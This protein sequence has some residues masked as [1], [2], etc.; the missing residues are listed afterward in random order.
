MRR[1]FLLTY[2]KFY[3]ETV[4]RK[5]EL[6]MKEEFKNK[7]TYYLF[8]GFLGATINGALS[9][10]AITESGNL[11]PAI[12]ISV[13]LALLESYLIIMM[14]DE[15]DTDKMVRLLGDEEKQIRYDELERID[16]GFKTGILAS[17]IA[18]GGIQ[19]YDTQNSMEPAENSPTTI[20]TQNSKNTAFV[21]EVPLGNIVLELPR[22]MAIDLS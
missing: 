8:G 17:L 1:G 2:I 15:V 3:I 14:E 9:G 13:A 7:A 21:N 10:A 6:S 4:H 19:V 5:Q 12:G 22:P 20:T 16:I 18:L 11:G